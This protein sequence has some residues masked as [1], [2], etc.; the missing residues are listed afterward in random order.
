MNIGGAGNVLV[1]FMKKT[2]RSEFD[3]TVITPPDAQLTPVLRGLGIDVLEMKGIAEKSF[4]PGAVGRYLREFKRLKPDIVHT[5]A[6]MSARIAARMY[7]KCAVIHTRHCA[8][9][10]SRLKKTFPLK[11]LLGAINNSLSDVIIAISPAVRDNLTETGTDPRKIFTMYN[12]AEPVRILSAEEKTAARAA[13]GI[14]DSDFVCA[15]IARLVPEKGHVY[16]LEAAEI[17][18]DL[19]VKFIIA[20][21]GPDETALRAQAVAK[22]L[23]NCIFTGFIDDIAV[24]ENITNLQLNASYGTEASS[25]SLIEGM[26]LGIPAVVSDFGGNPYHIS[27]GVNGLVV[28]QHDG[29]ALADAIRSLYE[30]PGTMKQMSS[31]AR[32]IYSERFTLE[33]MTENIQKLYR[34]LTVSGR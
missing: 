22:S 3:H 8:Y 30:A 15:V 4:S 11:N 23:S 13:L 31:A 34:D 33:I 24:I 25:M 17:L 18:K 16:I 9:P 10:Q 14:N 26:S 29:T 19:P 5:H 2:D 12:G 6:S 27:N 32:E 20:G 21:A 7:G 28:S 1:N